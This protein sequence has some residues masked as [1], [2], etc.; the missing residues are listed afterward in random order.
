M[1]YLNYLI[2]SFIL[3]IFMFAL[4][5]PKVVYSNFLIGI[6]KGL[7][8]SLELFPYFLAM[9]FATTLLSNSHLLEDIFNI[10]KL[11]FSEI[12]IQAIFKPLSGGASQAMMINIYDIYGI[13]SQ[14][15][16]ISS[17]LHSSSDTTLYVATIYTSICGLNKAKLSV[18][19]GLVLNII[20]FVICLILYNNFLLI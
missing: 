20:S 2:P 13:N 12:Y 8:T 14:E 9:V 4:K 7:N 15:G 3:I 5:N 6:N 11:Q 16:I 10:L 1:F 17:I 19:I 18:M